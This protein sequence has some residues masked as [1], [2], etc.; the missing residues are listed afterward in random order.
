MIQQDEFFLSFSQSLELDGGLLL[1]ASART[2]VQSLEN[3]AR[4][5]S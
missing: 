2:A 3:A 1:G 4:V 5:L